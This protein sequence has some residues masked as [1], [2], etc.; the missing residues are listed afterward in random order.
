[1]VATAAMVP[2]STTAATQPRPFPKQTDT[3]LGNGLGRLLAADSA[4]P[5]LKRRR[6]LRVDTEATAIRDSQ[7]RVLVD[8]TPHSNS[9]RAVFRTK[10]EDL[11]LVIKHTDRELGT[12]EGF[13]P[14]TAVRSL[15]A[16]PETATISQAL[17]PQTFAGSATSQG[18]ALQRADKVQVARLT[19][20]GVTIG[21]LSDSY[22]IATSDVTGK[23]LKIHAA[24]DVRS[25]D[26]PGRQNPR[27]TQPVVVIQDGID[28]VVDTDEGR[29]M[30]QIAHD[31]APGS[32]L[33]FATADTGQVGYAANI[34][35]LVN[36]KG[37][38]GANV[39]VDDVVYFDEPM[40]S[41]S[42]LSDAVD[43]VAAKG[44][45]YF[46]AAGNA[47]VQQSWDA[48]VRLLPAGRAVRGTNLNLDGVDPALYDGGLQDM[49][50]GPGT[51]VAQDVTIGDIGGIFDLQWDD[52]VD[53]NGP[54]LGEPIFTAQGQLTSAHP[55]RSFTFNA[56]A[57]QVGKQ[58][59]FRTD[60]IPSG[61]TDLVLSVTAP[62][63][64]DLGTIDTDFSPEVLITTLD[65]AGPYKITVS[66]FEGAT[67]DFTVDVSPVIEPTKV[68]TDFNALFFDQA[69][70]YVGAIAENNRVTG[71]PLETAALEGP[72]NLQ[73]VIARTGTGRLGATRLRNVLFDDMRFSEYSDP[74]APAIFGHSTAKGATAVAGYDPFR[75]FLPSFFTS[76]GGDLPVVF[77]SAGNR[78]RKPQIR[79]VPQLAAAEGGNT[80][81]F[82]VDTRQDADKQPNFS[83]TS[84]AGPHA[85][86]IAALVLQKAGGPTA[87]TPSTV[88]ERLKSSTFAHD[89]DPTRA[90]GSAGGL[91]V[92]AEGA[93]GYEGYAV[94]GAMS[95]P[96]FF[97]V[98]YDGKVPLT[99]VTFLGETA[100]PT[101][102]GKRNP[103]ASDG[104]VFDR[105]PYDGEAPF[106][107]DGFPFTIG[108]TFGGLSPR[109]VKPSFSVPGGGESVAGQY[110]HLTLNFAGGGLKKG[111]ALQFGVDRDLAVSGLGGS[112]EGNGADEL[113]GAVFLPQGRA[114][115]AGMRFVGVRADGSRI[116]GV[117]RNRL[118]HGWTPID[119]YGL[120]NAEKAVLGR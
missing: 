113:G 24:Q 21:A 37:R 48:P 117:L 61:E 87:L 31:V 107:A 19:G 15:A 79:R 90:S 86:G 65:Q 45:D 69:G 9:D 68:T 28:P 57:A 60:A 41:D 59:Q 7:R 102:L 74:L 72:D 67:G 56:T 104:I 49:D 95:D 78:Y 92:R 101:A 25:G 26:L 22:D 111:Q 8:L 2:T 46:S 75:P 76:P 38:C 6:G 20:K 14:L 5:S 4:V 50:P 1:M 89:L 53:L 12:L 34:R 119:G 98:G 40:F 3:N 51:D 85:A 100:S 10:A 103:P 108:S 73:M 58:V 96:R 35:R 54:T 13:A 64:T 88:R 82:A 93:Q 43:D 99:S 11:G 110:R 115:P 71:E 27:N 81:F 63:G 97:T 106:R 109:N 23:P 116:R 32:K 30:L 120:V 70:N 84:A 114:V 66:G 16:L 18:V 80:T 52:P 47:G 91:G 112:N 17:R 105:R 44:V 83:G 29:A 94:S 36:R 62:D 118:G 39:L 42:V 55:E 77:D 33:C